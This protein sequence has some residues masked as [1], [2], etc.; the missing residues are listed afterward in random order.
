VEAAG[1]ARI[2]ARES[3][4]RELI[5]RLGVRLG[6]LGWVVIVLA[7]VEAGWLTFDGT[8]ALVVGDYVTPKSG[9][10]AGQLGPW[11]K[12]VAAA[13]IEPRSTLMKS[14][15][16][17]LGAAWLVVIACYAMRMP[18]ARPGMLVC[19]VLGLWYLP[20]GTVLSVLQIVLLCLPAL[21]R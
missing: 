4:V 17:G 10:H 11:S 3:E 14:F 6:S 2:R 20:V 18:W 19:A 12:V 15:H 9:P 16:L 13:G 7:L 1:A 8:R 5:R 21:R